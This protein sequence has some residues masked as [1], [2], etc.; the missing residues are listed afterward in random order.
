MAEGFAHQITIVGITQ[1]H[2]IGYRHIQRNV[3][4]DG[5]WQIHQSH[6]QTLIHFTLSVDIE[7]HHN[8]VGIL[9][10]IEHP[11]GLGPTVYIIGFGVIFGIKGFPNQKVSIRCCN[12]GVNGHEVIVRQFSAFISSSFFSPFDSILRFLGQKFNKILEI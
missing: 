2:L 7:L 12:N 4:Y 5:H 3:V 10:A 6:A 11:A 9:V 1:G 8:G